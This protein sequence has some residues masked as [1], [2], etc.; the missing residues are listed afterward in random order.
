MTKPIDVYFD[1]PQERYEVGIPTLSAEPPSGGFFYGGAATI[2]KSASPTWAVLDRS[3]FIN[4]IY[5]TNVNP[6][7][8]AIQ[9]E[10]QFK[11]AFGYA[12]RVSELCQRLE[13]I[14]GALLD[15]LK[16]LDR[17]AQT[18]HSLWIPIESFAP[19]PY[20]VLRPLTAV[21]TPVEDGFEAG[22][23]DA[24]IFASG[25]TEAEAVDNL[26]SVVLET[27]EALEELGDSRL[28]PGPLKQKRALSNFI[29]RVK[30]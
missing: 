5:E 3:S 1:W 2:K 16:K 12:Q 17:S 27:Y 4:Q 9:L 29:R 19:E 26:K 24:S 25:D 8:Q 7:E 13:H 22:L 23:F 21:V 28:G 6:L 30:A 10:E 15:V 11:A 14:E 20:D 18:Q